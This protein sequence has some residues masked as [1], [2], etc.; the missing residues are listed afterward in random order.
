VFGVTATTALGNTSA[1]LGFAEQEEKRNKAKEFIRTT[2]LRHGVVDFDP[3]TLDP[4]T[5]GMKQ[6]FFP[7][8]TNGGKGDKLHPI[9]LA[10]KLWPIALT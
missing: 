9:E 2:L 8:N 4:S 5:D 6:Q 1:T 10:I 7:E 3:V